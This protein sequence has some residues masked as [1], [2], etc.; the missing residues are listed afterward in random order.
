MLLFSRNM[1]DGVTPRMFHLTN[2]V[3]VG[4]LVRIDPNT[5][6]TND[7][8]LIRRMNAVRSPYQKGEVRNFIIQKGSELISTSYL[9]VRLDVVHYRQVSGGEIIACPT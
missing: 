4:P 9:V 6:I 1:V 8:E 5:L 3:F 2:R 7:P